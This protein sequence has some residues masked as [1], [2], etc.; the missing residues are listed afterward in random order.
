M[1]AP[2]LDPGAD[3]EAA[4]LGG[5][6]LQRIDRVA[7]QIQ[8][9]LLD[10]HQVDID[11]DGMRTRVDLDL[12]PQPIGLELDEGAD[13]A[14][15]MIEVAS[16]RIG[17]CLPTRARRRRMISLARCACTVICPMAPT[18]S[19]V[20]DEALCSGDCSRWHS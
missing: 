3:A 20:F 18:R 16:V 17:G 8:Q 12:Q 4:M 2:P 13:L 1:A 7:D 5:R 14:H 6:L 9:D 11:R 10:L 15:Q 19:S